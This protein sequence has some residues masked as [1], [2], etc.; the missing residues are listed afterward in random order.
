MKSFDDE[1]FNELDR[2]GACYEYPAWDGFIVY[3][4]QA[5]RCPVIYAEGYEI[6]AD[7]AVLETLRRL[8]DKAGVD[9]V[10]DALEQYEI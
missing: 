8:P 7:M 3:M 2:L 1:I 10:Y 5:N 4:D 9:A 6:K